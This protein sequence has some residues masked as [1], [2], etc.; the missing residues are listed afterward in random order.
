MARTPNENQDA[1]L[2]ERVVARVTK[3][4]K[5]GLRWLAS[6]RAAEVEPELASRVNEGVI[7]RTLLNRELRAKGWP[8]AARVLGGQPAPA[9]Q[10]P[11]VP[12]LRAAEPVEMRYKVVTAPASHPKRNEPN[13]APAPKDGVGPADTGEVARSTAAGKPKRPRR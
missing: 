10:P 9:Y 13:E 3:S 6:L 7:L 2:A 12:P 8:E 11:T 5:E 4:E 1:V